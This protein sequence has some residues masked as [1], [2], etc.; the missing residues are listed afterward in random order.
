MPDSARSDSARNRLAAALG[1]RGSRLYDLGRYDEALADLREAT[2]LRRELALYDADRGRAELADAL[3]DQAMVLGRLARWEDALSASKEAAGI[4]R[5]LAVATSNAPSTDLGRALLEES[6]ALRALG[7]YGEARHDAEEA[8]E[9]YRLEKVVQTN[10]IY[11]AELG[12]ALD[13]RAQCWLERDSRSPATEQYCRR[14]LETAEGLFRERPLAFRAAYAAALNNYALHCISTGDREGALRCLYQAIALLRGLAATRPEAHR[15]TL[16]HALANGASLEAELGRILN[17]LP[18]SQEAVTIYWEQVM[19]RPGSLEF[20]YAGALH[21]HAQLLAS[22]GQS[23]SAIQSELT[24]YGICM[25]IVAQP[26]PRQEVYEAL[27]DIARLLE[28]LGRRQEAKEA[29]RATAR[30]R[31]K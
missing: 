6:A 24:A 10:G 18:L 12:A 13:T 29:R 2:D 21:L 25:H 15:E 31:P 11:R 27:N 26:Q 20:E 16:A 9:L 28:A 22:I 19:I 1:S 3:I 30:S 23:A 14:A 5:A 17:A 4:H 8:V 7:R